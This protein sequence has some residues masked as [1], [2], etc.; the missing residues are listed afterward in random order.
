MQ[1]A[2]ASLVNFAVGAIEVAPQVAPFFIG[3]PALTPA[4]RLPVIRLAMVG[5]AEVTLLTLIAALPL[6][7]G[8]HIVMAPAKVAPLRIRRLR[9]RSEDENDCADQGFHGVKLRA[10]TVCADRIL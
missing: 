6:P 8:L 9:D 2:L 7:L 4:I 3:H 1:C 10:F 5:L